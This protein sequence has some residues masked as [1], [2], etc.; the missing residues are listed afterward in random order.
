M[1]F[2]DGDKTINRIISESGRLAQKENKT[3]HTTG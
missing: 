1:L 2:G 3:R